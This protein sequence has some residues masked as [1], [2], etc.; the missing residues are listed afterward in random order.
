MRWARQGPR[1]ATAEWPGRV[2]PF[3]RDPVSRPR[4]S[5][6]LFGVDYLPLLWAMR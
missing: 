5:T 4:T 1:L 6:G 2:P 3:L